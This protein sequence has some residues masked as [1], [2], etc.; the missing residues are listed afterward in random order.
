MLDTF[1]EGVEY[2]NEK[3]TFVKIEDQ[4][5]VDGGVVIWDIQ[6][7]DCGKKLSLTNHVNLEK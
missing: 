5:L 3:K 2:T 1:A 7:P 4:G 6:C